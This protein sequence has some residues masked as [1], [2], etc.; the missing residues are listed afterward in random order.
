MRPLRSLT[1]SIRAL[2]PTNPSSRLQRHY[3]TP[4]PPSP[5]ID[6]ILNRLPAFLRPYTR[7]L[8]SAPVSHVVAFLFLH[9]LTAIVPLIGLGALFH[10]SEWLPKGWAEARYVNDGVEKFGRYFRRKGWFGFGKEVGEEIEVKDGGEVQVQDGGK[11]VGSSGRTRILVEVATAYAITKVFLPARIL[12]SVWATPWF[13]RVAVVPFSNLFAKLRGAKTVTGANV[14]GTG[15]TK[16]D[17][18][19]ASKGK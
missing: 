16:A 10:Y 7:S 1:S 12:L 11:G 2:K 4:S 19:S 3:T 13:A 8:R 6:R 9:E 14:A 15:A 5:K 18:Q 17:V